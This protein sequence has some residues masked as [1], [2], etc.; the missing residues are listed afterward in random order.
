MKNAILALALAALVSPVAALADQPAPPAGGPPSLSPAQRQQI[1]T[2]MQS[3]AQQEQA[4]Q[5]QA[6]SQIL[7]SLIAAH[8]T[9]LANIVGQLAIA[10]N[11]NPE[12]AAQQL[13]A[14][15]STGEKQA[16]LN[17]HANLETQ[18]K[19]LREKLRTAIESELPARPDGGQQHQWKGGQELRIPPAPDAGRILLATAAEAIHGSHGG[20]GERSMMGHGGFGGPPPAP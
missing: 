16:V 3:F 20:W 15:L 19:A 13:D 4:L 7:G 14:L 9:A 18:R 6:R 12:A 17:A 1:K 8:R 10:A 2:T 11:P 5:T